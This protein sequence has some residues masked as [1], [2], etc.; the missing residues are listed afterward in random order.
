MIKV[1][2]KVVMLRQECMPDGHIIE[3]GTI[4][5]V[6]GFSPPGQD[7]YCFL[8]EEEQRRRRLRMM[9]R[10]GGDNGEWLFPVRMLEQFPE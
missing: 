3:P 5:T 6:G 7:R 8:V 9:H 4:Y 1:G 10:G 2:D